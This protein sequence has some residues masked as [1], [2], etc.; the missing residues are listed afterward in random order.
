VLGLTDYHWGKYSDPQENFEPYNRAIARERLFS[1]TEKLIPLLARSG[2]PEKIYIPVGSD[3]LHVD[4]DLSTTTK[5][6]P[7]DTDGTPAEIL[8]SGCHLMGEWV[9]LLQTL[10]PIELILMSGNHDRMM[11]LSILLYLEALYKNNPNVTVHRDRTPRVY[12]TYGKNLLG[13]SHGE[14]LFRTQD[15]A[16]HMSREC[17]QAWADCPH[18]TI[19]TGHKHNEFTE[20]DQ[21]TGVVR[22]QLPSLAGSDRW[23]SRHGFIGNPKSLPMFL[24][25]KEHGL[26]SIL[27]GTP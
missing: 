25:G 27:Y 3:F 4:N 13:F 9:D 8:V 2:Q 26:F 17:P 6:T 15:L 10:A 22:R 14:S 20:T 12:H 7:Q 18:R 21:S 5:G 11:G 23:H 1:S 19:Y 24:H 16:G